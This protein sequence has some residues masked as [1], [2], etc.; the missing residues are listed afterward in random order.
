[1]PCS[2]A[3]ADW[4]RVTRK[5]KILGKRRVV[6]ETEL[7]SRKPWVLLTGLFALAGLLIAWMGRGVSLIGDEVGVDLRLG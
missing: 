7:Q 5:T 4:R 1:M 6:H 3:E 2:T